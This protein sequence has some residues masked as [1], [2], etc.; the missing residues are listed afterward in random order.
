MSWM[1]GRTAVLSDPESA[2]RKALDKLQALSQ[3]EDPESL[4]V[5]IL[6][7]LFAWGLLGEMPSPAEWAGIAL[8]AGALGIVACRGAA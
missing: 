2:K 4:V 6:G 5:P 7:V 3:L 8:M 1:I